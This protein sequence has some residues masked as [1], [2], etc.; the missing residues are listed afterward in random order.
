MFRKNIQIKMSPVRG[1]YLV[2][3]VQAALS[4]HLISLTGCRTG[5]TSKVAIINII[6]SI[7][8]SSPAGLL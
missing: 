7:G 3:S 5:T 4:P 6:P 1:S 8:N 2:L